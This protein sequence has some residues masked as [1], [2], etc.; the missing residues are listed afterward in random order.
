MATEEILVK[1]RLDIEELQGQV[2]KLEQQFK[3]ADD[4]AKKSASTAQDSFNKIGNSAKALGAVIASAFAVERIVAFGT[5]SVAAYREAEVNA[6]KL[7]A[8][9]S[10]NGGLAADFDRLIAQ[11]AKLQNASIFSDDE[12]QRAQTLALQFGL[13][14]SAVEDLLPLVVDFASATGQQLEPALQAVLAG[15]NGN[16]RALKIYGVEV[17]TAATRNDRLSS[18]TEQLTRKFDG[19]AKVLKDTGEGA[20]ATLTNALGDFQEQIGE[21]LAPT[22][23]ALA[24]SAADFIKSFADSPADLLQDEIDQLGALRIQLTSTNTSQEARVKIIRELQAK[25]PKYLENIDA[26]TVSNDELTAA[27]RKV[28]NQ[29]VNKLVLAKEDERVQE[30]AQKT[31]DAQFKVLEL[32]RKAAALLLEAERAGVDLGSDRLSIEQKINLVL[33]DREFRS[34]ATG[35]VLIDRETRLLRDL[36]DVSRGLSIANG[37]LNQAQKA[38]TVTEGEREA[39]VKRLGISL[40]DLSQST[41][42]A[43]TGLKSVLD[44]IKLEL[45][46]IKELQALLQKAKDTETSTQQEDIAK[47]QAELDKRTKAAEK[48]AADAEKA[49]NKRTADLKEQAQ[50]RERLRKEELEADENNL[51][52]WYAARLTAINALDTT[53]REKEIARLELQRDVLLRRIQNYKDYGEQVGALL[54]QLAEAENKVTQA[55][56]APQDFGPSTESFDRF[57]EN[58]DKVDKALEDMKER[59]KE[60]YKQIADTVGQVFIA[61]GDRAIQSVQENAESETSALD[62]QEERLQESYDKRI[63]GQREYEARLE[64]IRKKKEKAEADADRK[65]KQ[66][67]RQQ[68]IIQRARSLYEIYTSTR[69]AIMNQLALTPLP[70]GAPFVTAISILGALQ[71]GLVLATPLPKYFRGVR[72]V[73]LSGNPDGIDTVPAMLTKDER[74]VPAKRNLK[75]YEA[76]NALETD[77]TWEEF[78]RIKLIAPALKAARAEWNKQQAKQMAAAPLMAAFSAASSDGITIEQLTDLFRKGIKIRNIDE[79]AALMPQPKSPYR[80]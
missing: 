6:R 79:I 51:N 14:A 68:D 10:A 56:S 31:A 67:Q 12:V 35:G 53:E 39:V 21:K 5:A 4:A 1:Y 34:K 38:L 32:E 40:E 74:V 28:N 41:G 8:A 69:A 72:R 44:K 16:Q 17:D 42:S 30:R 70:A 58:L 78:K 75:M 65:T 26:E 19:Q 73:P 52:E 62:Q 25:Y 54:V 47:I 66:L 77:R 20:V 33:N 36:T 49:E 57:K 7:Q 24:R 27:L 23:D 50:E 11:N 48:A 3:K 61:L 80:N 64:E 59:T 18:I 13:Q 45:L 37:E 15:I 60:A 2:G 29:L 71:A 76:Y 43:G 22:L 55:K 46:S 9:V 63:I